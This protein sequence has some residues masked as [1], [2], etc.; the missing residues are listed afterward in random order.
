M[1][2]KTITEADAPAA[3]P[4]T[5]NIGQEFAQAKKTIGAFLSKLGQAFN[6]YETRLGRLNMALQ[7]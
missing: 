7:R 1:K 4:T 5:T 6:E 3:A 2:K